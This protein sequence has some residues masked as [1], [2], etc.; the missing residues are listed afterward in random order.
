MFGTAL[1]GL[2]GHIHRAERYIVI[3][4]LV[5][6]LIVQIIAFIYKRILS[7]VEQEEEKEGLPLDN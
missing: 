3:G 7:R 1:E 6:A 2:L 5:G 4:V